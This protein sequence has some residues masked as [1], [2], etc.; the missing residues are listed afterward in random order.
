[1]GARGGSPREFPRFAK[2][3]RHNYNLDTTHKHKQTCF[4]VSVLTANFRAPPQR[5]FTFVFRSAGT[6]S[7][8]QVWFSVF[9]FVGVEVGVVCACAFLLHAFV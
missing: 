6:M 3:M 2:S 1:M 8:Q 5:C 4:C 9:L 7:Y